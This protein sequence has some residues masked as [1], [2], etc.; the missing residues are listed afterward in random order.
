MY[1]MLNKEKKMGYM[2]LVELIPDGLAVS[3]RRTRPTFVNIGRSVGLRKQTVALRRGGS[4]DSAKHLEIHHFGN[5]IAAAA[6]F[7]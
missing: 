7:N 5:D 1:Y 4:D 3:R 6:G 2:P